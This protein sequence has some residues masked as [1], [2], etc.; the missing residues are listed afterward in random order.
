MWAQ[1]QAPTTP[2]ATRRN[3]R[4]DAEQVPRPR[5]GWDALRLVLQA[6]EFERAPFRFCAQA[7]AQQHVQTGGA[8]ERHAREVH[9]KGR[10]PEPQFVGDRRDLGARLGV[11]FR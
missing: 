11:E 1:Q 10:A 9:A 3:A 8:D 4:E 6:G 5:Q 2:G 7:E